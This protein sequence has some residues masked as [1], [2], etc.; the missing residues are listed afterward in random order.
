MKG[1]VGRM[2]YATWALTLLAV[3]G[4]ATEA[5]ASIGLGV[6]G[7]Y[8]H[9]TGDIFKG[10]GDLGGNGLWGVVGTIGMLPTVDFEFAYE[11]YTKDFDT[12]E[13]PARQ[14]SFQD[15]A[16][17]LT[18][19]FRLPITPVISPLWFHAGVGAGL[20]DLKITGAIDQTTQEVI[21]ETKSQGEWHAV[22]G[23]DVKV[24]PFVFYGEY[25]FQDLTEKQGPRFH[26]VYAGLNLR[27]Q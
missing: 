18:A 16:Y 14:G 5:A 20:H 11:R 26:S 19:K 8:Y 24:A 3:T 21:T 17:L 23:A 12:N 13:I 6:R 22:A 15:N 1:R 25:R 27:I 7:G 10:S 2:S 9:S 4:A